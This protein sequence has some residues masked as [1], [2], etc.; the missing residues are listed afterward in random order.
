MPP[1][2]DT[3]DGPVVTTAKRALETGNV[4]L[5]LPWVPKKAEGELKKAFK[6]TLRARKLGKEAA[7]VADHWFFETAVRVHREGEGASYTGLKTAGLDW[8]TVVPRAEEAIATGDAEE[9]IEFLLHTIEHE[10][11]ERFQKAMS[12][13][14]YD[15]NNVTAAREFVQANLGFVLWSHGLYSF[16]KGVGGHGEEG[17]GGHEH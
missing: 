15:E 13:K 8:G 10:L 6:R 2:C 17:A 7:E 16:V 4:N 9:A 5:I 1:H 11:R 14:N 3:M 12:R